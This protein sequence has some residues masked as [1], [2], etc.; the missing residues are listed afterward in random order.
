MTEKQLFKVVDTSK[1]DKSKALAIFENKQDAKAFRDEKNADS[2]I[3]PFR[4]GRGKQHWRGE[5]FP[6]MSNNTEKAAKESSEK[7]SKKRMSYNKRQRK[8]DK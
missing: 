5:S 3:N 8:A 2:K 7:V 6:G 4:V 1:G